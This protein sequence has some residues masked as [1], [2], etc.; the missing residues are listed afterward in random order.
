MP[1][2]DQRDDDQ[3]MDERRRT[4][5]GDEPA[6]AAALDRWRG[7]TVPGMSHA[8]AEH[9]R[10]RRICV[11][12]DDFGLHAGICQA[13][14]GLARMGHVQAIG[15]M[16]G[17]PAWHE[18]QPLLNRLDPDRVEL[19]LHLDL[20]EFPLDPGMA[21]PL[22]R[23][24][25]GG[26]LQRLDRRAL[27]A[28][29]RAQLAAFEQAIG[30]GPRYV[31]GHRHVHQLPVVREVLLSELDERYG[32]ARPWLRSTRCT[33]IAGMRWKPWLIEVL[34]ARGLAAAAARHGYPQNRRLLGVYDFAGGTARYARLMAA[35]CRA[36][37]D[38]DLLMC[39]PSL[40][41]AGADPLRDARLAEYRLLSAPGFV[42]ALRRAGI[43]TRTM[44]RILAGG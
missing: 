21:R 13:A 30:R 23:W 37:G 11:A 9:S 32:S 27:R 40:P 2:T 26:L 24:V 20:T 10:P 17:G 22:Q 36:A 35:W 42:P 38:G 41:H 7:T 8:A 16:V 25:F 39:H 6:E 3:P 1:E 5:D 34:G 43:E 15:C 33:P 28:E 29:I 44:S 4:A 12:A 19:G 31:D 14:I 18:W